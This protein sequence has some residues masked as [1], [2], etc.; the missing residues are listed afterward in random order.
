MWRSP[1]PDII[2][3]TRAVFVDVVSTHPDKLIFSASGKESSIFTEAHTTNV[4]VTILISIIILQMAHLI[5]GINV[6]DL[7][8]AIAACGNK[9]SIMTEADAAHYALM[10]KIVHQVDIKSPVHT[11]IEHSVPVITLFLEM[12]WKFVRLEV[13]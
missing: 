12:R 13:G 6:K 3:S 9:S 2:V 7:R 11:R 4:Q 1:R 8:T 10:R 5:S